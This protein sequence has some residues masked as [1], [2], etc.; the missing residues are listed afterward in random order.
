MR[1][2]PQQLIAE[3]RF[4]SKIVRTKGDQVVMLIKGEEK[5]VTKGEGDD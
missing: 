4:E 1:K 2:E 3:T 5:E